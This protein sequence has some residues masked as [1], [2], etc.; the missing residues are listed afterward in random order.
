MKKDSEIVRAYSDETLE[1][2]V[3][4]LGRNRQ[5]PVRREAAEKELMRRR[6]RLRR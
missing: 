1:G 4:D 2:I 6:K 3:S 5:W